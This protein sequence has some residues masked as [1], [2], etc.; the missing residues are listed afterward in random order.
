MLPPADAMRHVINHATY[1]RGQ[2]A[3]FLRRLGVVPPSTDLFRYYVDA[4]APGTHH[5][6]EG[7]V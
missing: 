7:C 2:A 4:R 3:T 1:H 6:A 5:V